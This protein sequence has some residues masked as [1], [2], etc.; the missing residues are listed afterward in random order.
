[1]YQVRLKYLI[2]KL[3]CKDLLEY[4]LDQYGYFVPAELQ[5]H[6]FKLAKMKYI[7]IVSRELIYD[8]FK[9][10]P[11]QNLKHSIKLGCKNYIWREER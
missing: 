11:E 1:M 5:K 4:N 3:N 8:F 6:N 10:K 2:F 9:V 7:R